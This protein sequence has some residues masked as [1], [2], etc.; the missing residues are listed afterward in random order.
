MRLRCRRRRRVVL[1]DPSSYEFLFSLYF[2]DS[3]PGDAPCRLIPTI[4]PTPKSIAGAT[5]V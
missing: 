2:F 3:V 1:S 4:P 5:F